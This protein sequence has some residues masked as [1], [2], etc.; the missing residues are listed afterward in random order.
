[1]IIKVLGFPVIIIGVSKSI[2][3]KLFLNYIWYFESLPEKKNRH[4][5]KKIRPFQSFSP[6]IKVPANF[7][8]RQ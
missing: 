6:D 4:D 1:M 2:W 7:I 3:V 8:P 5:G